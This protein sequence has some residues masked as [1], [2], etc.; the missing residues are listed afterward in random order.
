MLLSAARICYSSSYTGHDTMTQLCHISKLALL[1]CQASATRLGFHASGNLS[2]LISID[3]HRLPH[4]CCSIYHLKQAQAADS[5][6][7][8]ELDLIEE[9]LASTDSK[10]FVGADSIDGIQDATYSI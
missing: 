3:N 9:L 2:D 7:F 5:D 8:K 6:M 4:P 10:M 1:C